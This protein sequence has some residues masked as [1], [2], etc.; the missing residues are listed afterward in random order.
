MAITSVPSV[1]DIGFS[2]MPIRN[3]I[4]ADQPVANT[5]GISGTSARSGERSTAS[6]T[7]ADGEQARHQGEEAVGG[8]GQRGVGLGGQDGQTGERGRNP[9][10]RMQARAHVLDDLLLARQRHQPDPERQRR[11]AAIGGDHRLGEVGRHR[12][13]EALICAW[14]RCVLDRLAV[15]NRSGSDSAGHSVEAEQP[16]VST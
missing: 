12:G 6:S 13:Q 11:L 7:S 15:E 14:V 1:A 8:R 9:R 3:R 10:R 5:I 2:G 4:S 16:L